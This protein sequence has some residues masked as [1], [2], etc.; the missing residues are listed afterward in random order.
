MARKSLARIAEEFEDHIRTLLKKA[1]FEDVAGGR[2][3]RLGEQ[4]DA[5]GGFED[6]L[7][8]IECKT[9]PKSGRA[10]LDD[11]RIQRGKIDSIEQAVKSDKTYS[12]YTDIRFAVAT[13]FDIREIDEQ[14]A[15]NKPVVFLW[16][17][18]FVE[19]YDDL[20]RKIG[21]YARYN[22]L[23]EMEVSP[24]IQYT[25]QV[26]SFRAKI[27]SATAYIF[28]ANPKEILKWAYVARRE[29]GREKYYQRLVE[30]GRLRK[31]A[32]YIEEGN[33]F[34]NAAIV[35][36][37][38]TPEFKPFPEVKTKFQV[39]ESAIDFGC[40]SFPA[41][42]R[43]C[44]IVDGQH[45][46]YG[47]SKAVSSNMMPIVG[48][49]GA[50]VEDQ[51]QLFLD[52]NKTQKPVPS[53]LVWDLEGEMRPDSPDGVISR[54]VKILNRD[55]VLA[56]RIYVP[57]EGPKTRS[58]LKITGMCS[59]IKKR[60]L[61][62]QVLE[63]KYANPLYDRDSDRL[64]RNVSGNL[65]IALLAADQIFEEWQK[66]EFW[67]HNSGIVI[68]IALCERIMVKCKKEPGMEDYRRYFG[69]VN[70][71]VLRYKSSDQLKKLRQRCNSEGGRDEVAIEFVRAIMKQTEEEGFGD[72]IEEE[73]YEK[74]IKAVERGMANFVANVLGKDSKD[75][76]KERVPSDIRERV[77]E[78]MKKDK[79]V[80]GKPQ[81]HL[82]IGQIAKI[83]ERKDNWKTLEPRLVKC[84]FNRLEEVAM[85]FETI[86]RLRGRVSHGRASLGDAD[87][88]ILDGYLLRFEAL[89]QECL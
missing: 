84:G 38:S 58:Q 77:I 89:I 55:G 18:T 66:S 23:G 30:P 5:C 1:G 37:N 42:Y 40:L 31:I 46:L 71:H 73:E 60:K 74:R 62:E 87:E 27:A 75:W 2:D 54:I 72:D 61:T 63:H 53:D 50:S 47:M 13:N 79:S 44:W 29:I 21:E 20:I 56:G 36:F 59:A 83:V 14:E 12:K 64:V 22:L 32:Q 86:S 88:R 17:R 57:L 8:A 68:L 80:G 52:I 43:S 81:D 15:K 9:G 41:T 70:G 45:R 19:Y 39:W 25:F 3:F 10:I 65:N 33:Y 85:A 7:I 16:D 69:P 35:A 28:M 76:F 67:Y 78:N 82:T 24:R 51:A 49:E 4:I 48:I 11:I 34:P 26:P 6:T